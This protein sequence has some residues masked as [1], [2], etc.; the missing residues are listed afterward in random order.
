MAFLPEIC[1]KLAE[2]SRFPFRMYVD[3]EVEATRELSNKE[4]DKERSTSKW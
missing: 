1:S 4:E 3:E 2:E